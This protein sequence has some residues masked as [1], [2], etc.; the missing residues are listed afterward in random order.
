MFDANGNQLQ[1]T[2]NFQQFTAYYDVEN[3][4]TSVGSWQGAMVYGYDPQNRRVWSWNNSRDSEV[5]LLVWTGS[6]VPL[7]GRRRI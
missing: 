2:Y 3:R 5:A 7:S 6:G 1:F 4:M